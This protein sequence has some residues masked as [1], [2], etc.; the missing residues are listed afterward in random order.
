MPALGAR[1]TRDRGEGT[2][3]RRTIIGVIIT[4]T[5][6]NLGV[7]LLAA[8]AQQATQMPRI[9]FLAS[10]DEHS[11]KRL[12]AAFQQALQALGY[13]EGKNIV[14]ESRYA[15]GEFAR[16]PDLTAERKRSRGKLI[17]NQ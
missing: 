1:Q 4:C 8:Q 5:L 9:G 14:I 12:L 7:A 16:L 10:S 13:V 15:A 3:V 17:E 2:I 6:A 11:V